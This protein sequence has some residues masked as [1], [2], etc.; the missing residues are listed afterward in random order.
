MRGSDMGSLH[1]DVFNGVQYDLDVWTI[2]GDQGNSWRQALFDLTDYQGQLINIRFRGVTGL[3]YQSD[4]ALDDIGMES[5]FNIPQNNLIA[6]KIFP[7]PVDEQLMVSY[8]GIDNKETLLTM[9]D[10]LGKPVFSEKLSPVLNTLVINSANFSEGSYVIAITS[11]QQTLAV[12]K[13]I[14]MH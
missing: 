12:Q 11:K 10:V 8:D 2:S 9:Y 3:D 14:I 5:V 7:N 13:F 6:F 1:V 4:I